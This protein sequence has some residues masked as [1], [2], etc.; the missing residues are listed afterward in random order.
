M[1]TIYK[2]DYKSKMLIYPIPEFIE[3]KRCRCPSCNNIGEF[4]CDKYF[5]FCGKCLTNQFENPTLTQDK[6][7][8]VPS[9]DQAVRGNAFEWQIQGKEDW[10]KVKGSNITWDSTQRLSVVEVKK[11]WDEIMYQVLSDNPQLVDAEYV[12][13]EPKKLVIYV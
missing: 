11:R 1:N 12:K 7:L 8:V 10:Y 6:V 13:E 5:I 3:D 2:T 9:V 4:M